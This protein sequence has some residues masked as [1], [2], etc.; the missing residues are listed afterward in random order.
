MRA[1]FTM[2]YYSKANTFYGCCYSMQSD[3]YFR[4]S[5][6]NLQIEQYDHGGLRRKSTN[7]FPLLSPCAHLGQDISA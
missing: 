7:N 5:S 3:E 4:K 2:F 6:S 1:Q